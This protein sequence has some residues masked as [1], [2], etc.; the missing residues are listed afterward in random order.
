MAGSAESSPSTQLMSSKKK[1]MDR[2]KKYLQQGRSIGTKKSYLSEFIR[3]MQMSKAFSIVLFL[4]YFYLASEGSLRTLR[5]CRVSN[6]IVPLCVA[7]VE[8]L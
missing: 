7:A 2:S 6:N 8:E 5:I 1:E 3:E 4:L